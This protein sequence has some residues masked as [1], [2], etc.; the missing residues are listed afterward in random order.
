MDNP[1][2]HIARITQRLNE[3]DIG[4]QDKLG[5]GLGWEGVK[6]IATG[7]KRLAVTHATREGWLTSCSVCVAM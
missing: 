1:V 4:A 7:A 6:S 3:L 2:K 5:H